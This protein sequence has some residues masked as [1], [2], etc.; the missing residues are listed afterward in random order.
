LFN[1]KWFS[2]NYLLIFIYHKKLVN[3]K[4]F[5]IR[6]KYFKNWCD[7]F[8]LKFPFI[9]NGMH[10]L[11]VTKNLKIPCYIISNLVLNFLIDIYFV[12]IVFSI[13]SLKIWYDLIF[14]SIL[15]SLFWFLFF[16]SYL[17]FL[18]DFLPIIF[19]SILLIFIYFI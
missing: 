12:L 16:S 10:F 9:L 2:R 11:E 8:F 4:Y 6:E 19:G 15:S 17:F 14:I 18:I 7:F 1:E 3:E 13:L 5:L